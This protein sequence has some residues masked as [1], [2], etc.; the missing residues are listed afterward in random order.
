[1]E[2]P[3]RGEGAQLKEIEVPKKAPT[4]SNFSQVS[5]GRVVEGKHSG[6][7]DL[8]LQNEKLR[9]RVGRHIAQGQQLVRL[10]WAETRIACCADRGCLSGTTGT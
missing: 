3:T 4:H 6:L 2:A 1:M 9:P 8:I 10:L 5:P 7:K